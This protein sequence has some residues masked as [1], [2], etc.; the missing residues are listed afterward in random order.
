MA[1]DLV[2]GPCNCGKLHGMSG[3]RGMVCHQWGKI[4]IYFPFITVG[5]MEHCGNKQRRIEK[6]VSAWNQG[7]LVGDKRVPE[8]GASLIGVSA[9]AT[10]RSRTPLTEAEVD[11]MRTARANGTTVT[12]LAKQFGVHRGTVW[13]KT[14]S[15]E[16]L[17]GRA[18]VLKLRLAFFSSLIPERFVVGEVLPEPRVVHVRQ[19]HMQPIAIAQLTGNYF[20]VCYLQKK[21]QTQSPIC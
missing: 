12:T 1:Q 13:S 2:T 6:L 15:Y 9:E 7:I 18:L 8:R 21:G 11:T 17:N 4:R 10:R 5:L 14:R 3:T 19:C 16:E 20:P